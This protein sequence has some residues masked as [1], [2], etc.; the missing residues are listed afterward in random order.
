MATQHPTSPS[1]RRVPMVCAI[2]LAILALIVPA[3]AAT[4]PGKDGQIAVSKPDRFGNFQLWRVGPS[5]RRARRL[6][7]SPRRCRSRSRTWVDESPSYSA[8]GRWMV[9]NH[10]DDCF[11]RMPDGIYRMRANGTGR[12]L[13]VRPR[14]NSDLDWPA[15]SPDDRRLAYGV[16]TGPEERPLGTVYVAPLAKLGNRVKLEGDGADFEPAWSSK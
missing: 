9:Y 8:N 1:A 7:K 13:L 5:S 2:A 15:L 16:L 11:P 4:Q 3:A 10:Y 6:T 14:G 12:R